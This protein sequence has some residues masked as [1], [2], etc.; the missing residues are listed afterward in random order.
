[1]KIISIINNQIKHFFNT[2]SKK[3]LFANFFSLSILQLVTYILPFITLPYLVRVLGVANFGL[4]SF[5]SATVSYFNILIDYG[6]NFT[7]TR[8]ISLHRN[9]KKKLI[10][11]YSTVFSVKFILFVFSGILLCLLVVFVDRFH[12]DWSIYIFSFGIVL[13]Q[14]LFPVW[15]FQGLENMKYVTYLNIILKTIFT[16][17]IF[18]FIKRPEDFFL[19]PILNSIGFIVTG[20]WSILLV[21]KKFKIKFSFQSKDNIL[22]YIKDSWYIFVSNFSSSLYTT[23]TMVLLGLFTNNTLVGYYAMAEKLIS[24]LKGLISPVSQA[25][26][27]YITRISQESKVKTKEILRK[28]LYIFGGGMLL[29]SL[30]LFVFS[31]YI[32]QLFLGYKV[33]DS[34]YILKIFSIIPFLV[35]ID[36]I[37][38]TLNMLVFKRNKEYGSIIFSAGIIN[39]LI[40]TVLIYFHQHFGAAISVLIIELYITLRLFFYV[41]KSDLKFL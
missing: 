37:I 21:Q 39:L 6:F 8:E 35:T 27:P 24:A 33:I 41:H 7:A 13:G 3:R 40:A 29:V 23:T 12:E 5:A 11:I 17:A 31:S 22:Y 1:M 16:I 19:V 36:T 4:I 18:V 14:M 38:G 20:V 25:L 32:I 30:S 28:I 34:I 15:L 26:F 9:N 2:E 10:E